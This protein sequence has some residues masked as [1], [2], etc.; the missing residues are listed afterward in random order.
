MLIDMIKH[1]QS[2]QSNKSAISLQYLK[3]E[4][5]DGVHFLHADKHQ[6]WHYGFWWKWPDISKVPKIGSWKCFC[7]I[8]RKKV[9]Q[10]LLCSIVMLNIQIFTEVQLC[11]LLLVI[12]CDNLNT[13]FVKVYHY[14]EVFLN[15]HVVAFFVKGVLKGVLIL[16][17]LYNNSTI[18]AGIYLFKFTTG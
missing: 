17:L 11:S 18:P 15:R 8:L 3:K 16:R 10:L 7:N 2:T 13:F 14:S 9:S 4:V 6:S 1:S 5:R 12:P